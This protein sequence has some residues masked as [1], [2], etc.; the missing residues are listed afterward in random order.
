[1]KLYPHRDDTPPLTDTDEDMSEEEYCH[2]R[3]HMLRRQY[4]HEAEPWIKRLVSAKRMEMPVYFITKPAG[5]ATE[6]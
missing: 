4:E 5:P 1:M 3:L 2:F 6:K